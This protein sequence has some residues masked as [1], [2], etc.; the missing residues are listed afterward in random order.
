MLQIVSDRYLPGLSMTMRRAWKKVAFLSCFLIVVGAVEFLIVLQLHDSLHIG[1]EDGRLARQIITSH[2]EVELERVQKQWHIERRQSQ[3][4]QEQGEQEG[5]REEDGVGT[6][7][8]R[9]PRELHNLRVDRLNNFR[10]RTGSLLADQQLRNFELRKYGLPVVPDAVRQQ[11]IKSVD[12]KE[13]TLKTPLQRKWN[14]SLVG[15]DSLYKV[16][17]LQPVP[18]FFSDVEGNRL[19]EELRK[20][21]TAEGEGWKNL[22]NL[23]Q[24]HNEEEDNEEEEEEDDSDEDKNE[25]RRA[26]DPDD[27]ET[28]MGEDGKVKVR[29]KQE[30]LVEN[31]TPP[32]RDRTLFEREGWNIMLTVRYVVL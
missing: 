16:D 9:W 30:V 32:M 15:E 2:H 8:V 11:G 21:H 5:E 17:V 29:R 19:R 23:E 18:V 12:D 31:M 20:I 22:Y 6:D 14:F 24:D 13:F 7:E 25:H 3:T 1:E 4:K 27:F 28:Y 10:Q 26:F